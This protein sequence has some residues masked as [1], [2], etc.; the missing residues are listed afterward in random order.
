MLDVRLFDVDRASEQDWDELHE[1][2]F[3]VYQLEFPE[4]PALTR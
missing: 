2:Q 1:L 4:R 3:S